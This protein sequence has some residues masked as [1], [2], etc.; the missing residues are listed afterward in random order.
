MYGRFQG[1]GRPDPATE[2]A[3]SDLWP[4]DEYE[5]GRFWYHDSDFNGTTLNPQLSG[6][7]STILTQIENS[8]AI[9]WMDSEWTQ[10]DRDRAAAL[11]SFPLRVQDTP[12]PGDISLKVIFSKQTK[13][14]QKYAGQFA[15]LLTQMPG[16][17]GVAM[18]QFYKK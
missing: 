17:A 16:Q 8:E 11:G 3:E 18:G 13:Q 6:N 4:L 2:E 14:P 10:T 9:C 15:V 5:I 12:F 1:G 7:V